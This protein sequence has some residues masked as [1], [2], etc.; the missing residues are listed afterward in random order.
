MIGAE[1]LEVVDERSWILRHDASAFRRTRA[2]RLHVPLKAARTPTEDTGHRGSGAGNGRRAWT[3]VPLTFSVP[4]FTVPPSSEA[5]S[6]MEI[7]PTPAVVSGLGHLQKPTCLLA[8][9]RDQTQLVEGRRAQV[10]DQPANLG[11]RLGDL[12]PCLAR[13]ALGGGGI[14]PQQ[15]PDG[16]VAQCNG[17]KRWA[18]AVVEVASQTATLLLEGGHE[19][20]SRTLQAPAQTDGVQCDSQLWQGRLEHTAVVG[21]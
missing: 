16:V 14:P 6:R 3:L 12:R 18:D 21:R 4:I 11:D 2:A 17:G 20:L 7:K 1:G 13:Q 10:V 8:Q 15:V 19:P 5:R 9:S